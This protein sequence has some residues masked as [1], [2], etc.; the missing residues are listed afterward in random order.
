MV[1]RFSNNGRNWDSLSGGYRQRLERAGVTRVQYE[2]GDNLQAA[3]GHS[4][5]EGHYTRKDY[6][7]QIEAI[8]RE[9][10]GDKP[11][12]NAGRSRKAVDRHAETGEKRELKELKALAS[13]MADDTE[14]EL[15]D[16]GYED[17]EDAL[18]YH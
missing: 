1:K 15:D 11:S 13:H 9:R 18:Y 4:G 8:K 16:L 10:Y 7:D 12:F 14:Y 3:R 5:G 2:R 17:W 6:I